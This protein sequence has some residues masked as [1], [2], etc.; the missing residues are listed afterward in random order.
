M[1]NR[2]VI[3]FSSEAVEA[4]TE[5]IKRSVSAG[6]K[7]NLICLDTV[8]GVT[9]AIYDHLSND[10]L[11]ILAIANEGELCDFSMQASLLQRIDLILLLP[12]D[13]PVMKRRS[14]SLRPRLL[15]DKDDDPEKV[16]LLIKGILAKKKTNDYVLDGHIA[17][18]MDAPER[19]TSLGEITKK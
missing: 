7:T 15:L 10:P 1:Q 16:C 8:K 6:D 19:Y 11:V 2:K 13:A 14:Y 4:L 12:S 9:D 3:M 17:I 5:F 18:S